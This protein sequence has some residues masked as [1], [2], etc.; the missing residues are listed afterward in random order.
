MYHNHGTV[1]WTVFPC[2]THPLM[3][4]VG[5]HWCNWVKRSSLIVGSVVAVEHKLKPLAWFLAQV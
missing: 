1:V 5:L 4:E 2:P 3:G